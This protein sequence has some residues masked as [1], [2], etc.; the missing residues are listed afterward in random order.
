MTALAIV[1]VVLQ[2]VLPFTTLAS[3]R[4]SQ[5]AE[6][7]HVVVLNDSEWQKVWKAHSDQSTA[8]VDFA[9]VMVVGVFLGSRPTAGYQVEIRAVRPSAGSIVVEY[10][11]RS[12]ESGALVAQVM[13]SP[14]HLVTLPRSSSAKVEFR[15]VSP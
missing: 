13:T 6:P 8:A 4:D 3:G 10:V 2:A 15:K 12:P 7:Q 1:A 9:Q 14:F 11:E 5:I